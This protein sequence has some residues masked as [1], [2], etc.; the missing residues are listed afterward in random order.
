MNEVWCINE[1]APDEEAPFIQAITI[2]AYIDGEAAERRMGSSFLRGLDEDRNG[3]RVGRILAL[4]YCVPDFSV[5]AIDRDDIRAIE[6]ADHEGKEVLEAIRRSESITGTRK[7]NGIIISKSVHVVSAL[8]GN[9]ISARML[10]EL[11]RL[12]CGM[13]FHYAHRS[14]PQEC[15]SAHSGFAERFEGLKKG[16][17]S[18]NVGL[19]V[20]DEEHYPEVMMAYWNGVDGRVDACEVDWSRLEGPPRLVA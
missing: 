20:P 3:L 11:R 18:A 7:S 16:Y 14:I 12:H 10:Q 19:M 5:D 15:S 8:R 13:A 17:L 2:R 4:R 9:R 6:S 1:V